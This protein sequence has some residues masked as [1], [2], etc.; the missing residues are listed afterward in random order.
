MGLF[1]DR[2]A[3]MI[4]PKGFSACNNVR[5]ELGRVRTDGIGWAASGVPNLG[6]PCFFQDQ[7]NSLIF[8]SN[9]DI[10][11][12]GTDLYVIRGG[13]GGFAEYITPWYN[14]G[15]VS[16]SNGSTSVTGS[17]T[18]W[19]TDIQ[20]GAPL[21]LPTLTTN[22]AVG[23]TKL[24]PSANNA[25]Q[26]GVLITMSPPLASQTSSQYIPNGTFITGSG[27]DGG[28]FYITISQGLLQAMSS[29]Y[30]LIIG[31][32]SG[33]RNIVRAGDY[34]AFGSTTPGLVGAQTWYKIAAVTADNGI[35]LATPYSGANLSGATYV[36]RQCFT[37]PSGA[38]FMG[39]C[40]SDT[41]LGAAG[42]NGQFTGT[43]AAP[44]FAENGQ[45]D[46]WIFS[47]G[48]D[49]VSIYAVSN[50]GSL[51][52]QNSYSATIPYIVQAVKQ[53]RGIMVYGGLTGFVDGA[54]SQPITLPTSITSSD[55][56][57]PLQLNTGVAFQGIVTSGPFPISRLG[58]LGANLMIYGS[59]HLGGA[60]SNNPNTYSGVVTAASFVGYPTIWSFSD[61]VQTRGPVSSGAVAVFADR[62]QFLA[63]DGEYRYNGLFIQVMNDHVWRE[64]MKNFDYSRAGACFCFQVDKYGDLIWAVPQTTDPGAATL[65]PA[66]T[67]W[68]EHYMEQANSYLFKPFTQRDFPFVCGTSVLRPGSP[69]NINN[70]IYYVGDQNGNIWQL[71]ISNTQNATAPLCTVTWASRKIGNGR[72]RMLVTRVYPEL[73]Y[74]ASP[75]STVDVTLTLQNYAAGPVEITDTQDFDLS[76]GGGIGWTTHFRRGSVASVTLSDQAGVG[77]IC[78]GYDW[79]YLPGGMRLKA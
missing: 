3:H 45:C 38:A 40:S 26:C 34:I 67:A 11:Y 63:I 59:G 23:A 16:V 58:I 64:V 65:G 29:G 10:V 32:H 37:G 55:D 66:Q 47:N 44:A 4:D 2:P 19:N 18:R 71:Y 62:H 15:F 51:Q 9:Q 74:Q 8:N 39:N 46:M 56:G 33:L 48:I 77:W 24:Y 31:S 69:F 73:E 78:D 54:A 13:V 72:S 28:G 52:I 14:I 42:W 60:G 30:G 43:L 41:Y 49:P 57:F 53:V 36:I 1:L 76:Y 61:V 79:D 25:W 12:A 21:D 5:I 20:Y 50:T 22:A 75:L 7:F 70:P 27:T 68:V 6:V 35:T 17:G